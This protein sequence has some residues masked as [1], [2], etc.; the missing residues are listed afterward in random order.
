MWVNRMRT[1]YLEAE[2]KELLVE[3]QYKSTKLPPVTLCQTK[4]Q[5]QV[6]RGST[7]VLGQIVRPAA[8]APRSQQTRKHI[9]ACGGPVSSAEGVLGL[10]EDLAF[11]T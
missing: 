4:A 9:Q 8:L 10:R 7:K 11:P 3:S 5:S 2:R 1:P 6:P